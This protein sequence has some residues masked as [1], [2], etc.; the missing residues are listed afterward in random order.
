MHWNE[1]FTKAYFAPV[2]IKWFEDG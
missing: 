2:D 1:P